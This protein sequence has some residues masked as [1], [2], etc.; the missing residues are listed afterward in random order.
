M[1]E[2]GAGWYSTPLLHE[3]SAATGRELLTLDTSKDWLERFQGLESSLHSV[4]LIAD[5]DEFQPSRR[6]GMAFVDHAPAERREIEIRRLMAF[7][8]VFVIHDTEAAG[9]GFER[10][11][12]LMT[13]IESDESQTPWT[14]M[15][16]P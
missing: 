10:V 6:Y 14:L 3:I 15:C 11:L 2:L 13:I 1:L 16:R 12:P 5:W 7:V 9:Y 4:R 8:D